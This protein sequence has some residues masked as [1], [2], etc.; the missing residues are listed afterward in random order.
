MRKDQINN[1]RCY[2]IL[3][4]PAMLMLVSACQMVKQEVGPVASEEPDAITPMRLTIA[5][6]DINAL[7][8]NEKELQAALK[9]FADHDDKY[10]GNLGV[11]I[12]QLNDSN[13]AADKKA[14]GFTG[15][16]GALAREI[17]NIVHTEAL[18]PAGLYDSDSSVVIA[19]DGQIIAYEFDGSVDEPG[20]GSMTVITAVTSK[21]YPSLGPPKPKVVGFKW[22]IEVVGNGLRVVE[23]DDSD[24]SDPFP[25]TMTFSREM[26]ER[27]ERKQFKYK[28]WAE[29]TDI[30][31]EN[32]WRK[33]NFRW[34][35]A[36]NPS[37]WGGPLPRTGDSEWKRL[38][39][40]NPD[41]CIDMMFVNQPPAD[42]GDL[43]GPPWYCLGRCE[44][45]GI[46]NSR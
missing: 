23:Y 43:R 14:P 20:N 2:R 7:L 1:G 29:G 16:G 17:V 26:L 46:V 21:K 38:Y 9:L 3:L 15:I 6:K 4:W 41:S 5:G 27:I 42:F 19:M 24:P 35:R 10:D 40:S 13:L 11:L 30:V 34:S 18:G 25:N 33:E 45:P 44:H 31:V 32:V 36:H 22:E 37:Y 28:L 8:E 12:N 39:E